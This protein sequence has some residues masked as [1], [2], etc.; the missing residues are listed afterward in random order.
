MDR[1]E[2]MGMEFFGRHGCLPEEREKG[3]TF[4]V[5]VKLYL[6]LS[7]AGK[8]DALD[9]T[10]NYAE[11][12]QTVQRIVEGEPVRLSEC[13]AERIADRLLAD[14][15]IEM[16]RVGVHKPSAPIPGKF[17][18]VSVQIKRSRRHA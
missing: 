14:Y 8:D 4:F 11:V 12:F 1:I 15:A 13:L 18:D 9:K 2:L 7:A 6:D 17:Q 16:V 10:V 5:D 3:Q